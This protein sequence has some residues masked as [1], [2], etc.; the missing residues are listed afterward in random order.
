MSME[1]SRLS[2]VVLPPSSI[3][4]NRLTTMAQKPWSVSTITPLSPSTSTWRLMIMIRRSLLSSSS[5]I[6]KLTSVLPVLLEPSR[7]VP[8]PF[9]KPAM[10]TLSL[11]SPLMAVNT[12]SIWVSPSPLLV[13]K[14]SVRSMRL[15]TTII[16]MPTILVIPYS[17]VMR[18][19]P[20]LLWHLRT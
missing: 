11:T 8:T 9:R 12:T 6:P 10:A 19:C 18:I 5:R 4:W 3:K 15:I 20:V 13:K 17:M 14:L 7:S 16:P 2:T 1:K